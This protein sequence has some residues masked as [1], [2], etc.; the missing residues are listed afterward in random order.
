MGDA[1]TNARTDRGWRDIILLVALLAVVGVPSLFTRDLWNPDE[2]RYMEVAREMVVLGDYVIPHLNGQV[3]MEKP[4]LFFWLA[5]LLWRAGC[6]LNSGR[7]LSVLALLGALLL[8]C[9]AGARELGP[10][11]GAIGAGAA[12]T[13]L[14]M[15]RLGKTGAIDPLLTLLVTAAVLSG[16]Q[17]MHREG[18]RRFGL[19]LVSYASMGLGILA[20]GPVGA[21]VPGLVLLVYGLTDRRRVRGGG[22]A[23]LAGVGVFLAVVLAWLVPAILVGGPEYRH[24]IL[25]EQNVGRAFG[26]PAHANPFYYYLVGA[27]WFFFPWTAVLV[28]AAAAALRARREL[29]GLPLLAV[30]W[31]IVP[32]LF[33]SLMAG[34]RPN[35]VLP[36]LPASGL[37][38]GWYLAGRWRAVRGV[39]RAERALIKAT[40]G[41]L[42]LMSIGLGTMAVLGPQLTGRLYPGEAFVAQMVARRDAPLVAMGIAASLAALATCLRGTFASPEGGTSVA[43]HLLVAVVALSV[44]FD[45]SLT[46]VI[47][48]V[49]SPRHFALAVKERAGARAPL[50]LFPNDFS[51]VYNLYTVRVHLPVI[52]S[53][54][55]LTQVLARPGSFIIA[56]RKNAEAALG[57]DLTARHAVH[58]ERVGHR[59]MVLLEGRAGLP[60]GDAH[61]ATKG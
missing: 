61:A 21:I 22:L 11:A 1:Q 59:V 30:V 23:H 17:A 20:K 29:A 18:R 6:G 56:R 3:Y 16:Y 58:Q 28:F 45:L 60:R 35:Y 47:N 2:P 44:G 14:L 51:G 48:V 9:R 25:V 32:F 10:Q 53:K 8:I 12:L 55:E 31:L 39:G 52:E 43:A 13:C 50:Y 57:A 40:F 42:C 15:L 41:L 24:T 36:V 34:K 46:P 27:S 7:L 33:F 37:L 4:P 38:V 54:A 19:W 26:E 49:K 5:G